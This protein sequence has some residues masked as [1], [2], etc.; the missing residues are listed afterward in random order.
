[1]NIHVSIAPR[2]LLKAGGALVV[3]LPLAVRLPQRAAQPRRRRRQDRRARRG[4]Q[5]SR[6]DAD[7]RV[8]VYSGKVDLGTGVRTAL[9]QIA[10]E[11]LDVPLDRVT[12]VQGD[13]R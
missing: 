10:A 6:I 8:T 11:E 5:L 1:M 13:T 4:R 12:I 7:G 3:A 9:A 2:R